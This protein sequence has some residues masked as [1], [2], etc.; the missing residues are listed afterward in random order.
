ML[1]KVQFVIVESLTIKTLMIINIVIR[2]ARAKY[3]GAYLTVG[4]LPTAR[5]ATRGADERLRVLSLYAKLYILNKYFYKTNILLYF[6]DNL[7]HTICL[8][9]QIVLYFEYHVIKKS[10]LRFKV[11]II[12]NIHY[13]LQSRF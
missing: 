11:I 12:I 6:F 3:D 7:C 1:G 5:G 4:A 8:P 13:I 9:T 2:L 10:F